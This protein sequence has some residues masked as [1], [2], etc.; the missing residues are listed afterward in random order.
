VG[1]AHADGL[2]ERGHVVGEQLGGVGALRLAA[3]PCPAQVNG[4][5]GEVL[6]VV[7]DLE[8][9]T[10]LVGREIRD[11]DQR[12]ALALDLVVDVNAVRL[13]RRHHGPLSL[14]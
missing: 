14:G 13:D 10:G 9:I 11:E 6:G 2:H 5:A 7:R 1:P 4:E 12:L 3:Q 8:R